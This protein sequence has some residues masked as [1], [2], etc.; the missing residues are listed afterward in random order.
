MYC[1]FWILKFDEKNGDVKGVYIGTI[2]IEFHLRNT[3][4]RIFWFPSV[5]F[6]MKISGLSDNNYGIWN[7]QLGFRPLTVVMPCIWCIGTL[8]VVGLVNGT[9]NSLFAS[10]RTIIISLGSSYNSPSHTHSP[11][12]FIRQRNSSTGGG[13]RGSSSDPIDRFPEQV[14]VPISAQTIQCRI[15]TISHRST[16]CVQRSLRT[17][18]TH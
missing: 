13:L 6:K 10:L 11:L 12:S 7:F 4:P 14:G 9:F 5:R 17:R 16:A 15:Y 1:D 3:H 18:L 2:G 8:G